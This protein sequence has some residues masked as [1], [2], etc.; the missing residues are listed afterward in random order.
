MDINPSDT[1]QK[2][3]AREAEDERH[4]CPLQLSV[5]ERCID[6]WTNPNDIV[7]DPFGGIGSTPYVALRKKRRSIAIE[8]KESYYKQMVLNCK[9]ALVESVDYDHNDQIIGQTSLFD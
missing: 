8:L 7:L 3:S 6:L 2:K 9:N 5:I 1:L 4:I